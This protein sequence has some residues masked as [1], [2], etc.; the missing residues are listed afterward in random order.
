M[1][2]EYDW[3]KIFSLPK[4]TTLETKV[5]NVQ[6]KILHRCYATDSKISKWNKNKD[7]ICIKCKREAN[8]THNFFFCDEIKTFWHRFEQWYSEN[9]N[10]EYIILS[11][12]DVIFGK[13]NGCDNDC[14]NHAILY[15]KFYIHKQYILGKIVAFENYICFYKFVLECEKQRYTMKNKIDTFRKRFKKCKLLSRT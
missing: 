4:L 8:I 11:I 13:Y 12:E 5:L 7:P 3:R 15:A 2:T 10:S 14:L 1:I 6:Y 9:F